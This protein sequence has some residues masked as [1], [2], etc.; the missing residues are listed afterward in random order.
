MLRMSARTL[1]SVLALVL[2][3]SVIAPG[4]WWEKSKLPHLKQKDFWKNV[5]TD[6]FVVVE[7]Y[8]KAC[9]YCEELYP[10]MNKIYEEFTGPNAKR[11]DIV[12]F[13]VDGEESPKISDALAI[14]GYPMMYTFKPND[15]RY[16]DKYR[17]D[18]TYSDIKGYLETLPPAP[19]FAKTAGDQKGGASNSA[20]E[21]A[22]KKI[23]HLEQRLKDLQKKEADLLLAKTATPEGKAAGNQT[24][25]VAGLTAD[26]LNDV[27]KKHRK[28]V[29]RSVSRLKKG[30]EE[31]FLQAGKARHDKPR[32]EP[33][34]ET[35]ITEEDD[36]DEV[37]DFDYK[38]AWIV[39]ITLFLV[40]GFSV[41]ILF[42]RIRIL[43][44]VTKN[45][46]I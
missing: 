19:A 11:K 35:P 2:L 32:T 16:P 33:K 40:I 24:S 8:T 12:F 41:A 26:V 25:V 39:R 29:R 38:H 22:H 3:G 21:S 42:D 5:G 44:S 34:D 30:I 7:F 1:L 20:L 10:K 46:K 36:D 9:P 18:N 4:F 43:D 23:E 37:V 6:K 28:V 27:L 13:K 14:T 17:F 15:K 31:G 45:T